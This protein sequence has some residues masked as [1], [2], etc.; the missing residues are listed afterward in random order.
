M[1]TPKTQKPQF[2]LKASLS[3]PLNYKPHTG[4]STVLIFQQGWN[5]ENC[6]KKTFFYFFKGKLKPFGDVQE[7][8]SA[9]KSLVSVSTH[10]K[11]YKQHQAKTRFV[12]TLSRRWMTP[13]HRLAHTAPA[14]RGCLCVRLGRTGE[15]NRWRAGSRRR[16]ECL[17]RGEASSWC[18][19]VETFVRPACKYFVIRLYSEWVNELHLFVLFYSLKLL[20]LCFRLKTLWLQCFYHSCVENL[21]VNAMLPTFV[22][23]VI[24]L[25]VLKILKCFS[26]VFLPA[27]K[28]SDAKYSISLV[29][30]FNTTRMA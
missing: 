30:P 25:K 8:A 7:N 26:S 16:R 1:T 29:A 23:A 15:L 6:N 28:D 10:Q 4:T 27:D 3:R 2:D 14:R 9:N 18:D 22:F 12:Q 13:A 17:E 11:N 19:T 5:G 24:C 20:E 21:F